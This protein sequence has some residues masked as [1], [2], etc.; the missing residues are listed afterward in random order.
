MTVMIGTPRVTQHLEARTNNC[1]CERLDGC[2]GIES[3]DLY[4]AEHGM[5]AVMVH[6]HTHAVQTRGTSVGT[7]IHS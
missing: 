6:F 2:G 1:I 5:D 4:C 3:A 7:H